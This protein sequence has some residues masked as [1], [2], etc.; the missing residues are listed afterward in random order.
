MAFSVESAAFADAFVLQYPVDLV[1]LDVM[2]RTVLQYYI[3]GCN[4]E[5]IAVRSFISFNTVKKT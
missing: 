2:D 5:E 4:I 3:E 1:I